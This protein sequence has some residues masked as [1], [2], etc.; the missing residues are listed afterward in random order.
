MPARNNKKEVDTRR[1][2]KR[3]CTYNEE[4]KRPIKKKKVDTKRCLN[5][6]INSFLIGINIDLDNVLYTF[7]TATRSAI[8]DIEY[9][10][11]EIQKDVLN[12]KKI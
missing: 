9:E 11:K 5:K 6:K 7:K 4:I 1:F 10:I 3:K 8:E 2:L 12:F